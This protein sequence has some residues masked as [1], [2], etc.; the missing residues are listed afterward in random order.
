[1]KVENEGVHRL[2]ARYVE[3]AKIAKLKDART[4]QPEE[5]GQADEVVVSDRAREL[6]HI[7]RRLEEIENAR[8]ARIEAVR[9]EIEAGTYRV[10]SDEIARRLTEKPT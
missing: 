10:D 5:A 4:R 7:H 1:M 8:K 9:R 3:Q 2:V 6:Q